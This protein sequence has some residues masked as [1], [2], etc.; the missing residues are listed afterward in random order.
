MIVSNKVMDAL[1]G[2]KLNLYE[3]KLWVALLARGTATAGELAEIANVPRSRAYDVLQTLANKGFV[4]LQSGKPIKYVA[5]SPEEA[6]ERHKQKLKEEYKALEES[7]EELKKSSAVKELN[8]IYKKGVKVLTPEDMTGALKGKVSLLQKMDSMFRSASQKIN[9]LTTPEGLNDLTK[10]HLDVLKK[11]KEKGADIKV[12]VPQSGDISESIKLL[13]PIA[14][15]RHLDEKEVPIYGRF[16]IIDGKEL[17]LS[18]T[19]HKE[20]H[21]S[22]DMAVWTKSEHAAGKMLEPVFKLMWSKSKPV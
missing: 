9:I 1:K 13:S 3:R 11:A 8:E 10:H 7:I 18:L 16:A 12:L 19:D 4:V 22:Q 6:L 14:E 5:V 21:D 20:V 17:I 15:I 2:I